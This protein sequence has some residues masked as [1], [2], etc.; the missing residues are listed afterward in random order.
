MRQHF[1]AA[2]WRKQRVYTLAD[3]YAVELWALVYAIENGSPNGLAA[4]YD[5]PGL[6]EEWEEVV[7][8]LIEENP[9]LAGTI[10][11]DTAVARKSADEK[12]EIRV[13]CGS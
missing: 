10:L 6:R 5:G 1:A 8:H 9:A 3:D 11:A 2:E 4:M 12:I 13:H 7:D